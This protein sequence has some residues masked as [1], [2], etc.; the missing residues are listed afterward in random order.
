MPWPCTKKGCI[1]H[2]DLA[3]WNGALC[4]L[5]FV[6][7]VRVMCGLTFPC[8]RVCSA[9]WPCVMNQSTVFSDLVL[10]MRALCA[11][12]L[13]CQWGWC[14]SDFVLWKGGWCA[15]TLRYEWERCAPWHCARKAHIVCS[16]LAL[17]KGASWPCTMKGS[18]ASALSR[19]VLLSDLAL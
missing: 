7:S 11:L 2:S 12:T 15:L 3:L 6:L 4:P 18:T 5:I 8:E 9:I 14:G 19:G 17:W 16:D 13:Y 1:V 10:W